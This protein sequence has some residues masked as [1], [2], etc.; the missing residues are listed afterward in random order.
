MLVQNNPIFSPYFQRTLREMRI[1]LSLKH[2]N[3]IDIKDFICENTVETLKD[4]YIVQV[5]P[6]NLNLKQPKLF[7]SISDPDG[8]RP[9]QAAE[10]PE[11][12][13]RPHLLLPVSDAAWSEVH[14]L[15]QCAA[16]RP[17]A[18]QHPAQLKL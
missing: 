12:V 8:N 1:L 16:Q 11:V 2:E 17:Q 15:S 10:V 13:L 7:A 5:K 4:I 3:I 14:P 18:I 6:S 9:A